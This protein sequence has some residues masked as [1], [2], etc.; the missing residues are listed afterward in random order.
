MLQKWKTGF[1]Y[2]RCADPIKESSRALEPGWCIVCCFKEASGKLRRKHFAK[3]S[4]RKPAL[5]IEMS[6]SCRGAHVDHSKAK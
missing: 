4:S 2:L 5:G 1:S 6:H 3:Q